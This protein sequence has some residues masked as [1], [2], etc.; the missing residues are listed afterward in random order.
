VKPEVTVVLPV[1]NGAPYLREAIASVLDQRGVALRL[2]VIDNGSTDATP[3]I[4]AEAAARD[5]RV[6]IVRLAQRNLVDALNIGVSMAETPLIA[7]MDA[8]D[9]SYPDRLAEQVAYL[10]RHPSCVAVGCNAEVVDEDGDFL[11]VW[12]MPHRGPSITAALVNARAPI[13]HPTLVVRREAL[14]AIGGYRA[15]A[16]PAEDID[17]FVRLR[18]IGDLANV[19]QA[20]F[21]HRRH[22]AATS[23]VERTAQRARTDKAIMGERA[24]LGLPAPR[25]SH[26]ETRLRRG[27]VYHLGC[28]RLALRAG[29]PSMARKHAR[30]TL[31]VQP[32]L[33]LPYALIVAS[34]LPKRVQ[35]VGVWLYRRQSLGSTA[36]EHTTAPTNSGRIDMTPG[37]TAPHRFQQKNSTA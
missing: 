16:Y 9:S 11:G 7:R 18:E 12:R 27:A 28:A 1:W 37:G 22:R 5:A 17:L 35:R 24:R 10:D 4:A 14:V 26:A 8:D 2:I 31:S 23:V 3:D 21:R 20:L 25:R 13:I 36:N 6:H 32:L 33:A 19:Q 34:V 29:R 30:A 15:E